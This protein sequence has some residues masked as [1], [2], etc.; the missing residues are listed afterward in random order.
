[1]TLPVPCG[2]NY[3]GLPIALSIKPGVYDLGDYGPGVCGP[4]AYNLPV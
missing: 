1:M 2:G 4:G 3:D